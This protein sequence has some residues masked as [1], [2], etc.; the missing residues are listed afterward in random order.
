MKLGYGVPGL[1]SMST[2]PCGEHFYLLSYLAGSAVTFTECLCHQL[3]AFPLSQTCV[4]EEKVLQ[5]MLLC[6]PGA[7]EPDPGWVWLAPTSTSIS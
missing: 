2:G 1:E 5:S 6:V 3:L 4:H 7:I